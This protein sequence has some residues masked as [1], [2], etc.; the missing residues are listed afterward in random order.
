M[1]QDLFDSRPM[2]DAQG[3]VVGGK[4]WINEG[5]KTAQSAMTFYGAGTGPGTG[6]ARAQIVAQQLR[7][8][9]RDSQQ[10]LDFITPHY[11]YGSYCV[12]SARV[13]RG[14]GSTTF[15][16]NPLPN[17]ITKPESV[18]ETA[19]DVIATVTP[20][21]VTGYGV[22]AWQIALT[23][24][25]DI[26]RYLLAANLNLDD[27]HVN[28]SRQLVTPASSYS[29]TSRSVV[30]TRYGVGPPNERLFRYT[31]NQEIFHTCDL[32]IAAKPDVGLSRDQWVKLTYGSK[33]VVVRVT[34]QKGDPGL[35]LSHGGVAA[36]LGFVSGDVTLAAP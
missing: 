3:N 27:G 30:A 35:D 33:S 15:W 9:F 36:A 1:A 11:A 7:D 8:I 6:W 29:G 22:P 5:V 26:R 4:V 18:Y 16:T 23:W 2:Q 10:D 24:A 34:D 17:T 14:E 20:P 32:T 21:E 25:R 13:R 12:I 31:A 28:S 19:Y